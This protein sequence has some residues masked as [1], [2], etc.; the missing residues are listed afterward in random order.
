VVIPPSRKIT[1]TDLAKFLNAWEQRP[2]LVSLGAQKNFQRLMEKLSDLDGEQPAPIPDVASYKAMIAKGI[3][4]KKAG[5]AIR[6]MFPAFQGNVAAYTVALVSNRL[7]DRIDLSKIWAR[8][9]ISPELINQ[10]QIWAKEVDRVLHHSA[11]GRM[12]SEWAKKA[13]CWDAVRDAQYSQPL[14]GIPEVT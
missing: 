6:P 10:L 4:F 5:A 8:Q 14:G 9:A 13:E 7:G 3:L 11:Q 2:D 12:I 1:K